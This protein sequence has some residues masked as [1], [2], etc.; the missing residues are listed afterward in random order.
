MPTRDLPDHS[1]LSLLTAPADLRD[2]K[3]AVALVA[4]IVVSFV[5][6]TPQ[7]LQLLPRVDGFIP[8]VQS[9]IFATDFITA[10]LLFAHYA[11]DR[12]RALVWL[13]SGYLFSAVLVA[14]QTLTFPGAFAPGG[15]LGAGPQ[16]AAWLYIPW[17][18][19]VP[20]AAI[21]YAGLKRRPPDEERQGAAAI[22]IRRAVG[23]TVL[24]AV[25]IIAA[26]L[27]AG[28]ALPVLIVS[29]SRFATS[30]SVA[31]VLP[32]LLSVIAF[33]LLW[34]QRT[35]VL[36]EWL[37][38]AL[39]ASIAE[40]ALIVFVGAS[41]YTV[42]FYTSRLF[43]LIVASAVLVALLVNMTRLYARLSIAV[44]ALERQ[45][46]ARLMNLDVVVGSI[47]HEIKQPLTVIGTCATVIDHLLRKPAIDIDEVR[48][49][50]SDMR[51]A[52]S[53]IA[54]TIDSLRGLF[55]DPREAQQPVD[56]NELVRESL[57]V[58]G[59][60]LKA[61]E[62]AVTS[63]L[64]TGLPPV[65]GHRGQ[66]REVIVNIVQNAVDAMAPLTD[67]RRALTVATGYDRGSV[68]IVIR[69]S[70]PGIEPDRLPGL[71][72]A[73]ISTKA[74]GMG[75]GLSLC[76]MI[77][78]RHSGRLSVSSELGQGTTFEVSLPAAPVA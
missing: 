16:T 35:S 54:E 9:A 61:R 70:G 57:E 60:E 11:T 40:T 4:A 2:R 46:A 6:I 50:L 43:A 51:K 19:A 66:L 48:L 30:A 42:A 7:A 17:H 72:T 75:L 59:P 34:R 55:R 14:A 71:F 74:T 29:D 52:S 24:A 27:L 15:L 69:D 65:I 25:A 68:A 37:T 20:A 77:V 45:R 3:V 31:T 22:T 76:Q 5:V 58:L 36:D 38:V 53:R 47:G 78:D 33:V 23:G 1:R 18:I 49:N 26:V 8:A 13:A 44:K 28:D 73:A 10:V 39:T 21:A 56:L 63:E 64:A 12:I 32:L 67:R 62:I 41:R